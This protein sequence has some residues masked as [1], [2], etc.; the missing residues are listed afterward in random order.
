MP[1][2]SL[3]C[4]VGSTVVAGGPATRRGRRKEDDAG[5]DEHCDGGPA[6]S[7]ALSASCFYCVG[8][9][10]AMRIGTR[11]GRGHGA[12]LHACPAG[13]QL[14]TGHRASSIR[15]ATCPLIS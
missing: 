6:N 2:F 9:R 8:E 3:F 11:E 5:W 1:L 15:S 14:S 10:D 7:P 12:W 4:D 13:F